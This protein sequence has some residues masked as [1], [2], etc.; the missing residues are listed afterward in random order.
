MSKERP[1]I[2]VKG[3][4]KRFCK[5]LK[6]SLFYG[7][8]D[9]ISLGQKS[10]EIKLRKDEFW[11]VRDVSFEL[12]K[13]QCL[14]LIGHNGAGK[15]TLLKI[16][17]G[18]ISPD[19]GEVK[20]HGRVGALIEL[21][22]GFNP[23][24]TGR[25]NI[26]NNAAVLGFSRSAIE[27]KL[28]EIISF[29]EVGEFIDMPVQNY[30][31]GMK[32]RLGFAVASNLDPDLLLIDEVLA[33]GDVGFRIKCYNKIASLLENTAVI[34]VSHAMPQVSKI[35][36]SLLLL[37][38]GQVE[39]WGNDVNRGVELYFDKFEG[40]E[41]KI[42]GTGFDVDALEFNGEKLDL[43]GKTKLE[44][45]ESMIV[46]ITIR[47]EKDYDN[48]V[49]NTMFFDRELKPVLNCPSGL[50]SVKGG[51]AFNLRFHI[52]KPP[53]APGKFTLT[54]TFLQFNSQG[55]MVSRL[56]RLENI[57]ELTVHGLRMVTPSP[58]QVDAS[59]SVDSEELKS[60]LIS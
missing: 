14:G 5:N 43:F 13:G 6:R 35:S 56:M 29:S 26:Y 11:A 7:V 27:A 16:L 37:D 32:V 53:L 21:G 38:Q 50:F 44:Y 22:A 10:G 40:E 30:S 9:I 42:H 48:L 23:I 1:V 3:V 4:S 19:Y 28:D 49:F 8:K 52:D 12:Y 15:S 46:E 25:E 24:L 58:I 60:F 18:I 54:G 47:P 59:W 34:F 31:S 41:A 20:I 45:G 55:V 17:N 51:Q 33:V 2:S 57:F 36:S 39:Y